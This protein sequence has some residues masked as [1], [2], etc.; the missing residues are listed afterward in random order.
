MLL[1]TCSQKLSSSNHSQ[2]IGYTNWW[3]S[4]LSSFPP[5]GT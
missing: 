3:L 1:V 2:D 5:T 4:W